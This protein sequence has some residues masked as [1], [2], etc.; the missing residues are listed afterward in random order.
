MK[1]QES[2]ETELI[3]KHLEKKKILNYQCDMNNDI[4]NF[5]QID[6]HPNKN[7]YDEIFNCVK[8]ILDSN[9]K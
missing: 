2:Y 1:N 8:K 7:G 3:R 9:F 6:F 4:N 5:H